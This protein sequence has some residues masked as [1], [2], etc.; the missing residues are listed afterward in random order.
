MEWL[1][2]KPQSSPKNSIKK[3]KM[4]YKKSQSKMTDLNLNIWEI[5]FNDNALN[6][7]TKRVDHQTK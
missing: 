4:L 3:R 5:I 6:A 7:P 1:Y 2:Q